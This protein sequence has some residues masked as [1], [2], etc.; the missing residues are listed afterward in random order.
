[1]KL[2][3]RNEDNDFNPIIPIGIVP[4]YHSNRHRPDLL[5]KLELKKAPSHATLHKAY[6]RLDDVW[7]RRLNDRILRQ[8]KRRERGRT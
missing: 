8:V 3:R 5:E 7:F 1:M 4:G 2:S 6:H